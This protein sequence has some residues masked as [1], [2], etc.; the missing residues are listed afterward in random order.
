MTKPAHAV[1][2]MGKPAPVSGCMGQQLTCYHRVAHLLVS[3]GPLKLGQQPPAAVLL[4]PLLHTKAEQL[5]STKLSYG[6]L[7]GSRTNSWP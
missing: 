1:H 3:Y 5:A 6:F 4:P 2:L 7:A